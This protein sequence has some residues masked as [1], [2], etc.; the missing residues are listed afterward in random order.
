MGGKADK[1]LTLLRT[2][3]KKVPRRHPLGPPKN[4]PPSLAGTS[5]RDPKMRQ[6]QRKSSPLKREES[7]HP[8]PHGV[9]KAMGKVRPSRPPRTTAVAVTTSGEGPSYAEITSRARQS[10]K[11]ADL[12]IKGVRPKR[13]ITGGLILEILG[14]DRE[15]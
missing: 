8:P 3:R 4:G 11:L 10:I 7:P 1:P 14:E 13:A 12:G 9:K 6:S 15:K 5:R 2:K